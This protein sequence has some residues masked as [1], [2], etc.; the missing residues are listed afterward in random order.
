[1]RAIRAVASCEIP[2][3]VRKSLSFS[4]NVMLKSSELHILGLDSAFEVR[5]TLP[6]KT[7]YT[8]IITEVK[9]EVNGETLNL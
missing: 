9:T 1:M 3:R 2:L 5:Y 7:K 6:V 4:P 8:M